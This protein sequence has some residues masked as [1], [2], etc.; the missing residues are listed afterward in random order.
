MVYGD[1][2]N[3]SLKRN[4]RICPLM[5]G[6]VRICPP[7]RHIM[8]LFPVAKIPHLYPA[9]QV[10]Q[11]LFLSFFRKNYGSRSKKSEFLRFELS[12][13]ALNKEPRKW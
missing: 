5:S 11:G 2:Y 1:K 12:H 4:V 7:K 13:N 8:G 3:T 9:C 10:F 6:Y